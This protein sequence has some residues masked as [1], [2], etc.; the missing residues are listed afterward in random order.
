MPLVETIQQQQ[1][2]QLLQHQPPGMSL[3]NSPET[4]PSE[5]SR[6][7]NSFG[8][9][10]S[11]SS[12]S[13][14]PQH[15]HSVSTVSDIYPYPSSSLA[16][17]PSI[18]SINRL[19]P[20]SPQYVDSSP[21]LHH[22]QS[23]AV[24]QLMALFQQPT[25]TSIH[26]IPPDPLYSDVPTQSPLRPKSS[27]HGLRKRK[28]KIKLNS[29]RSKR[30]FTQSNLDLLDNQK[31]T[32]FPQVYNTFVNV[33][34]QVEL[35]SDPY[36]PPKHSLLSKDSIVFVEDYFDPNTTQQFQPH[37]RVAKSTSSSSHS[38]SPFS[39]MRRGSLVKTCVHCK[40]HLQEFTN[41][42][43]SELVCNDCACLQQQST[44]RLKHPKFAS[45]ST[46]TLPIIHSS[47]SN[48][49]YSTVR[50]KLRWRWRLK[51]LLPPGV[52]N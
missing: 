25:T 7:S 29:Q 18:S 36:F 10:T 46:S 45:L 35:S 52:A 44:P 33:S 34:G 42:S 23:P 24:S 16:S 17:P 12:S 43:F 51:G 14:Y 48:D 4:A 22:A 31:L 5:S 32:T 49:W 9:S 27:A 38:L 19:A 47:S 6:S 37:H 3:L 11:S 20:T 13:Y 2:Q 40:K 39:T 41:T 30:Q 28:S 8:S 50:R 21:A 15:S 26:K 1:K